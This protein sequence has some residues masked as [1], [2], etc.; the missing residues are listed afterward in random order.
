M[1]TYNTKNK[2]LIS[3]KSQ[4]IRIWGQIK[5]FENMPISNALL[6]LIKIT[7]TFNGTIK[8]ESLS[9]TKSDSEGFYQ[10]NISKQNNNSKLKILI[11]NPQINN[12]ITLNTQKPN[13]EKSTTKSHSI[14]GYI[15]TPTKITF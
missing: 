14:N 12:K 2:S 1:K 3:L 4:S 15:Y 13:S 6:N 10:F 11:S 8:Y 9:H 7:Q 5:N